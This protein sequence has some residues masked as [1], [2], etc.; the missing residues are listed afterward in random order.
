MFCKKGVLRVFAK[1]TGKHVCQSLFFD[2]FAGIIFYRAPLDDCFSDGFCWKFTFDFQVFLCCFYTCSVRKG[3][4]RNFTKFTGK[5]L[6]QSLF[7]N[8]FAGI[9]FH[10]TPLDDCFSD[11][12]CRHKAKWKFTFNFKFFLWC[13]YIC[14]KSDVASLIMVSKVYVYMLSKMVWSCN[15]HLVSQNIVIWLVYS[16]SSQGFAV[17]LPGNVN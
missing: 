17:T 8:K 9:I 14:L 11:G 2:K 15:L 7:F 4:L 6:C 5:H 3:V 13:F 16:D 12:F 1:F 10:R